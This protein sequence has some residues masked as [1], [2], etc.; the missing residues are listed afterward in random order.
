MA[1]LKNS[2]DSVPSDLVVMTVDRL[3]EP[4]AQTIHMV[5]NHD[6]LERRYVS[7]GSYIFWRHCMKKLFL[8]KG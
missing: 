4:I 6:G 3:V 1:V 7:F 5:Y 8:R 2:V